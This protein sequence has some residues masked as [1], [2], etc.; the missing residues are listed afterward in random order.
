MVLVE[1]SEINCVLR[2]FQ[3]RYTAAEMRNDESS[4]FGNEG[5]KPIG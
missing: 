3:A 2:D 1:R 5:N 4:M